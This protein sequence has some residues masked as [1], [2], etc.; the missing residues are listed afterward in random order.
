MKFTIG[1]AF[2]FVLRFVLRFSLRSKVYTNEEG[3]RFHQLHCLTSI[4]RAIQ[5]AREGI[6]PGIDQNDNGHWPH[7]FDYLRQVSP[8]LILLPFF[9]LTFMLPFFPF[10]LERLFFNLHILDNPMLG[11]R[12]TRSSLYSGRIQGV[13]HQRRK[14]RAPVQNNRAYLSKSARR[15]A[16][17]SELETRRHMGGTTA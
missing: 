15:R 7:C 5:E 13:F 16:F 10:P 2:F 11:R 6:D 1:V 17:G 4:R 12:H 3:T 9:I 14:R 8:K